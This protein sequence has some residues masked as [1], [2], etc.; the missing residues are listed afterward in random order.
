LLLCCVEYG[1]LPE[2]TLIFIHGAGGS[3]L[4]WQLQLRH[5][6]EARAIELPG[7]PTGSGFRTIK[8]YTES[9]QEYLKEKRIRNP[10]LIGHS[11]GG[12][13][14]IEYALTHA[15]LQGLVLVGTG[16]RLRVS[17]EL[18]RKILEDYEEAGKL[19]AQVSVSPSCEPLLVERIAK[20]MLKVKA[21]VTYGDF[22]ACNRFDRMN[23]VYE[24]AA[25]TLIVCGADDLLTPPKYSQYLHEKIQNSKLIIVP[26]A[27]HSVM[28]EKHREFN[29]AIEAFVASLSASGPAA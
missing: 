20:E 1:D 2:M 5:F 28:L 13:I 23:D 14:A 17:Q 16:A 29:A 11:M 12:A 8:E 26:G 9:V 19:I 24:I 6:N 4:S 7:H 18:M 10:V 3:R 21:D 22:E 27:G 15:D 25:Q